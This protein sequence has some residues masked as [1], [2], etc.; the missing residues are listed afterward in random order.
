MKPDYKPGIKFLALVFGVHVLLGFLA[1]LAGGSFMFGATAPERFLI[2]FLSGAEDR[3]TFS[4]SIAPVLGDICLQKISTEPVKCYPT[5]IL[6]TTCDDGG[7]ILQTK[8]NT[9]LAVEGD[10][11]D[12]I[13]KLGL[14]YENAYFKCYD[15]E[16]GFDIVVDNLT[17]STYLSTESETP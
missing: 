14:V 15:Y 11:F 12:R 5:S 3:V 8:R 13:M 4:G 1:V 16:C 9:L 10:R 17:Y 6:N 7:C 2:H